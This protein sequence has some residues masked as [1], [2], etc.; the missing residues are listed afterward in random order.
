MEDSNTVESF[1]NVKRMGGFWPSHVDP[2]VIMA[3]GRIGPNNW[4]GECSVFIPKHF[5]S[6]CKRYV[7]LNAGVNG[8]GLPVEVDVVDSDYTRVELEQKAAQILAAHFSANRESHG[9]PTVL[10]AA[11]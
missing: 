8:T 3:A 9:P 11:L 6:A 4:W 7:H 5:D 2:I 1:F 10:W